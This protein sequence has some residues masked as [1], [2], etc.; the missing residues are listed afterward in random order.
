[1]AKRMVVM[2]QVEGYY[3]PAS[4]KRPCIDIRGSTC[5]AHHKEECAREWKGECFLCA[6]CKVVMCPNPPQ[7]TQYHGSL[8]KLPAEKRDQGSKS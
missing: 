1:M 3:V 6:W 2:C 8:P 4:G 5:C 7:K